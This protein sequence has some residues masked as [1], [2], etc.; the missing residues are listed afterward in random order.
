MQKI[1]SPSF[2]SSV[3]H[4]PYLVTVKCRYIPI[5]RRAPASARVTLCRTRCAR[6]PQ[7]FLTI[8]PFIIC[9]TFSSNRPLWTWV[10]QLYYVGQVFFCVYKHLLYNNFVAHLCPIA[11]KINSGLRSNFGLNCWNIRLDAN[12]GLSMLMF[13]PSFGAS[14]PYWIRN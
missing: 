7:L 5:K 1:R 2:C 3:P 11:R 14:G 12:S 8:T 13:N 9:A 6:S 10:F 4:K